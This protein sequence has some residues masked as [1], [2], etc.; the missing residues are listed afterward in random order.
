MT[1]TVA[2]GV[3]GAREAAGSELADAH[4]AAAYISDS[5]LRDG[6]LGRVGLEL[7]AHCFDLAQPLRR[8][9]WARLRHVID[10]LPPLPGGSRVTVEP[11]GAVELSG[12]PRDGAPAAIAAMA[13]DRA[14]LRDAFATAGLGLVLLGADPLRPARRVNPAARYQA[15]EAF[16]AATGTATPGAGDD[17]L[18]R[19]GADQPG[20]RPPPPVGRAGPAGA[21]P[22]AHHGRDRRELPAAARQVH[23][24]AL[25]AATDLERTR[26]G[27]LRPGARL[28]RLGRPGR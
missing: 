18:H 24:L 27:A 21:R 13:A 19:I 9:D 28:G 2:P 17:D 22:R 20:R 14:V 1:F 15:M 5:C 12:P 4:A 25:G 26:R 16:F 11:G 3:V 6:P 7:E 10:A 8:P 23:R